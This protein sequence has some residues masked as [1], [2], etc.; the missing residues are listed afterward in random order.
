MLTLKSLVLCVCGCQ[1]STF[2]FEKRRD[3]V[4]KYNRD[5]MH[6]TLYAMRRVTD[7]REKRQLKFWEKRMVASKEQEKRDA[8]HEL[9]KNAQ[10]LPAAEK[11]A[12][13][14]K[15]EVSKSKQQRMDTDAN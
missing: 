4:P 2:E 13:V 5:L 15:V 3:V 6:S 8:A 1:D 9:Q 10:L 11:Q 12:K 7:I 14:A